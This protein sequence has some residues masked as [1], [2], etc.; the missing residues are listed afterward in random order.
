MDRVQ[1]SLFGGFPRTVGITTPEFDG[2]ELKQY[3]VHTETEVDAVIDR[4]SGS[5]NVYSS[6]SRF[7]PQKSDGRYN[8]SGVI[9]DKVSFDLD[10]SAKGESDEDRWNHPEIAQGADDLW[11][12]RRLQSSDSVR[13][14]V[15]SD[16]CRDARRMAQRAIEKDIPVVGVFSGFG[17]HIHQLYQTMKEDVEDKLSSTCNEWIS[18]L[19]LGT[20]DTAASGKPFR[21]MRIPNIER[22]T[23]REEIQG[24]GIHTVPLTRDELSSV[25]P[26]GLIE[27]SDQPRVIPPVGSRPELDV[28]SEYLSSNHD[29]NQAK[30]RK[31]PDEKL[32]SEYVKFLVRDIVKLP[33]IAERA[34]GPDPP[35]EVRVKVGVHFLNAGYSPSEIADIISQL[36]WRNY[37]RETTMYQIRHLQKTGKGDWSCKTLRDKNLCIQGESY[38]DCPTYGYRG[39]NTPQ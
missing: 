26:E 30:Q 17:L 33:C 32:G 31:L 34:L 9:A 29:V 19:S 18:E 16:V 13:D 2:A 37:D 12:A 38:E 28:K 15:L 23:Y 24:T 27:K 20:V 7:A 6:I 22:I 10:S 8:G 3:M 35:N 21:I 11:V 14:A 36:G 25:S 1:L 4:V 39:G 5:R